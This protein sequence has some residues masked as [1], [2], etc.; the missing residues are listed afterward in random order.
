V[1]L[2]E[3]YLGEMRLRRR[4]DNPVTGNGGER[5]QVVVHLDQETLGPDGAL[6]GTLEDGSRVSA[7]TFRRVACDCGLVAV[8]HDGQSLDIGRRSRSIPPAIRRALRLRDRGCAFPGC[9]HTRFVH[10]HHVE[11]WLHGGSTSL[12]NLVQLC[13]FHHHLVHE[14]GWEVSADGEGVFS[15]Y[16]PMGG[17]LAPVPQ[18]EA[19]GDAVAWLREWTRN[20]GLD[21]DSQTSF[22]L[23]D[24]KSPN[25][26]IAVCA[27]LEAC[28]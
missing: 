12:E 6:G 26:D 21:I 15:F 7:E 27:L 5:F 18:S 11:H 13:S 25:Y 24:G 20:N 4:A 1:R 23:G 10:A 28:A 3:S 22:P 2:A 19:V 9:T 16:P 14:G 8:H 17:A